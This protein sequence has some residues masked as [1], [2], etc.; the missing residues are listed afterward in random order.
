MAQVPAMPVY[1]EQVVDFFSKL[2]IKLLKDKRTK[3]YPDILSYAF[4]I[5][6]SSLEQEREKHLSWKDRIGRG[7]TFHYAPANVPVN[8]VVSMTSAMSAGNAC[9]I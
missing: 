8:F 7:V 2:S 6:R 5:R 1:S 3:K 9:V 4:W